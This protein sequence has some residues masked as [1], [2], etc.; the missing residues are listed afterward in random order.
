[1]ENKTCLMS[2][3]PVSGSA[4]F[5]LRRPPYLYKDELLLLSHMTVT[6][7]LLSSRGSQ[8]LHSHPKRLNNTEANTNY[9]LPSMSPRLTYEDAGN[10][11]T[12]STTQLIQDLHDSLIGHP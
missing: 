3:A 4:Q 11:V 12:K 9:T 8:S 2:A 1:M 5:Q 7:I 6:W 10:R